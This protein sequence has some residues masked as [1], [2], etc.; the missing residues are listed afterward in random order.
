MRPRK[1]VENVT[2]NVIPRMV[3]N[4]VDGRPI[5]RDLEYRPRRMVAEMVHIVAMNEI[6]VVTDIGDVD[7]DAADQ[8]IAQTLVVGLRPA[9]NFRPQRRPAV[10]RDPIVGFVAVTLSI[11]RAD[12]ARNAVA[13]FGESAAQR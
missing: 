5:A 1:D 8:I 11:G 3:V 12:Q 10:H 6:G 9:Q 2:E 13:A 4:G 7:G